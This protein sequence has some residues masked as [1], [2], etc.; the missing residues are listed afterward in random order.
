MKARIR[1]HLKGAI[2]SQKKNLIRIVIA[3]GVNKAISRCVR[4]YSVSYLLV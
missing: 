1:S 3:L 4:L 2:S